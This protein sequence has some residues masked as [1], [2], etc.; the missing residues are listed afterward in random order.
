MRLG[1]PA[2]TTCMAIF[3]VMPIC[4][5]ALA[6]STNRQVGTQF[7][8]TADP[9]VSRPH[10]RSCVVTLFQD[11][12][13]ALFSET[14]QTFSFAPPAGCAGPYN[15][16]VLDVDF[17]ENA[18]TQ[19]D[20][21]AS[22]YLGN[23]NIYFGTT[24]EP[25]SNATNT[26]HV[27]RDITDYSALLA[28]SQ[29]GTM[30]LQN[31]TGQNCGSAF[32]FLNGVFTVTAKL[33]L[34]PAPGHSPAS[35]TPDIVLPIEQSNGSGGLNFP[36]FL[37]TPTDTFAT[38]FNLPTNI[39]EVYLD[40]VAQSQQEDEQWY[41]C[42]PND[43]SSINDLFGCGNTDF[44]EGE[45]TIDGQL[46]GIA[47]VSP[48]V[49]TGFL[50][51]QWQPIPAVQTLDFVPFRVNLTPFASLLSDGN[52]H[53]IAVDVFDRNFSTP[54]ISS[55]FSMS[56]SL[57]LFLDHGS[58]QITGALT[59]NTLAEPSPVVNENL[60]SITQ[61]P[62]TGTVG[63]TANRSFSI[64]GFV[65]TS[66]GKVATT[67]A[68]RREFSSNQAIDFDPIALSVL[69]QS[70]SL[71]NQ[72][73]SSTTVRSDDGVQVTE[74]KYSFPISVAVTF[75]VSNS[76]FGL[77]VATTQNY[78]SSKLVLRNGQVEDFSSATNF[79]TA[80][81]VLP[82]SSV[83]HYTSVDLNGPAYDCAISTANNTLTTVSK[84]CTH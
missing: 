19:F 50:P 31:C 44:R 41:A 36:A 27:E 3:M 83:Q 53:T 28:S 12:Q 60:T 82:P 40:I 74:Q 55:F 21:T 11:Y 62:V 10:T 43:L 59:K 75:P 1:N 73:V 48:W 15:K 6:Q 38:T 23:A 56:S 7:T 81:D 13:F 20:R 71:T 46:A 24:P 14:T 26:W 57:L 84:G 63:V 35:R 9:L 72:L 32:S 30:V 51:D 70:L 16:V 61:S 66:H 49:F 42:F 37:S 64:S 22:I 80:S 2:A 68:Q 34:F 47:P 17:S 77:T 52:P 79:A 39:E 58:P 33:E 4:P 8:V 76:P 78:E 25:L 29:Q 67:I 5:N 18:G 54:S 45:V 69:N 65:N